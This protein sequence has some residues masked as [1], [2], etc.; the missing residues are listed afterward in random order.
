MDAALAAAEATL[1]RHPDLWGAPLASLKRVAA[2]RSGPLFIFTW[3]QSHDGLEVLGA[4]VQIQ[5]HESGRIAALVAEGVAIPDGF[6]RIPTLAPED[7]V[8]I[9]GK[10]K[11]INP[12]D[13]IEATD[14]LIFVKGG[15]GAALARLAWRVTVEQP[16]ATVNEH[17]YVDA[18]NG[19]ILDV[20]PTIYHFADV[21]GRVLGTV[22]INN[23][24]QA[25]PT[26][27]IPLKDINVT[28]AGVGT[29]ATNAN[30]DYFI[31][32]ALPGPFTVSAS[33]AGS[34]FNINTAQGTELSASTSTVSAG[35]GLQE[36]NLYFNAA[37]DSFGTAQTN[38][39]HHHSIVTDYAK[40][41]LPGFAGF[42]QQV[43][44][45]N[46]ADTCNA[47]FNPSSNQLNFFAAGGGCVNTSF[48]TV[49]YHEFGHSM[50]DYYGG[51]GNGALSEALGDIVAMYRTGQ[52]LV[53]QDFFGTGSAIRNGENSKVWPASS[54]GGQV[55][56][57]GETFM[58][59][60]WQAWKLLRSSLGNTQG[61][62]VAEA[63]F[64]GTFPADNTSITSAVTQVFLL[65]DNDGNLA[66]GTPNYNDLAQA[67]IMKGFTPPVVTQ[68][69]VD[70][71]HAAHPDTF[72][73]TQPYLIRATVSVPQ[74]KTVAQV[75][76]DYQYEGA[77]K[78]T[79]PMTATGAPGEYEG[80]IPPVTGPKL[81]N[82]WI[83]ATDSGGLSATS[84]TGDSA[85]RFAVGRKT[86]LFKDTLDPAL[87]G[88]TSVQLANQND[89]NIGIPQVL[90]TNIYDP[91]AAFSG[92]NCYGNDLQNQST[93]QDGL[94]RQ[95]VDNYLETP[96]IN[97]SGRTGVRLRFRR[98]LTVESSQFDQATISVNGTQVYINPNNADLFDS[99]W[100][101]QDI[102]AP[103]A[104]N[105]ASFKTRFRMDSDGGLQYGGWTID[106]VEVYALEA[107]PVV[108][109][110]I[111]AP[112][113]ILIGNNL[114]F[115]FSGTPSATVQLFASLG[116]GPGVLDGF[117]VI[118]AD[119]ATI[120]LFI[121]GPLDG[122]GTGSLDIPIPYEPLLQGLQ[123]W[124][125]AA[126][127]APSALPQI[128][129]TVKTTFL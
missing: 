64:I 115:Q 112:Q 69:P 60:A 51:I 55:H 82:Y 81:V 8:A 72:N 91:E 128:S 78:V 85:N 57:V 86:V 21:K 61:A 95:N 47:N 99:T 11:R 111:A 73:Q 33:L 29:A 35:A 129:N 126:A 89:W 42:S 41:K 44:T 4:R 31:A 94:Y 108:T 124:W 127:I 54:C 103:S 74:P 113:Q 96:S 105:V 14:F 122:T 19:E 2:H 107:T 121:E 3:Q 28:V 63:V 70:I 79:I 84:P 49:M 38:A 88:W 93:N 92:S 125:V 46:I 114:S 27:N 10:G 17:V 101:L 32:T 36:G 16:S 67:A 110:N 13:S 39:A 116:P 59:F 102:P 52:P 76:L 7:A 15:N 25:A 22:N 75:L 12:G 106:D 90:G 80:S 23:S 109:L 5:V 118:G 37:G 100:T 50:D 83:R 53:G 66:N 58:G 120:G 20:V 62:A 6:V 9:V 98:W 104:N 119:L 65:D 71:V 123:L 30:G 45:V 40:S 24:G 18:H 87:P 43:V 48:S 68:S 34:V 97:A 77:S 56:C 26:P 1:A 117:G